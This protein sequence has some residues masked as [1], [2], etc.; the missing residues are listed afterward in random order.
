[1]HVP[2]DRYGYFREEGRSEG[3]FWQHCRMTKDADRGVRDGRRSV[4]RQSSSNCEGQDRRDDYRYPV[5]DQADP[6]LAEGN[7]ILPCVLLRFMVLPHPYYLGPVV[8]LS[9]PLLPNYQY[10]ARFIGA[11]H[12][13][14]SRRPPGPQPHQQPERARPGSLARVPTGPERRHDKYSVQEDFGKGLCPSILILLMPGRFERYVR[15]R[16]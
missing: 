11:F 13:R 15:K 3:R 5:F 9:L 7:P 2:I 12:C 4:W 10:S 8:E 16:F 6:S 14:T 1:M